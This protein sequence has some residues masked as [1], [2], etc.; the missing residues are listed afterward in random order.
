MMNH[1]IYSGIRYT[2]ADPLTLKEYAKQA[3][4]GVNIFLFQSKWEWFKHSFSLVALICLIGSAIILILCGLQEIFKDE[5]DWEKLFMMLPIP[6]III[7]PP[8]LIGL[9]YK[10]FIITR[11][12]E[13]KLRKFIEQY[14]P[15]ATN[16]RKITLTNYLIDYQGQELEVAFYIERKYNE[17][18]KKLQKFKFIVCGLHYTTRDGDYSIIGQNN[19]LTKEFLHDWFIYAKEKPHCHN[20]YVSTQLFFAKFPLSTTIMRE[21]VNHT[22]EELLYMTEKFDLIPIKAILKE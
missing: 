5:H 11:R 19:Q 10:S 9:Y 3:F 4:D 1:L 7:I 20:I 22:L 13:R 15:E 16:I 17:K 21:T 14:L 12:I 8:A 18:R 6:F 2:Y